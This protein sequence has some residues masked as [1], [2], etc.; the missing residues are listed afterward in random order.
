MSKKLF[1]PINF[2]ASALIVALA[3]S[4]CSDE[5]GDQSTNSETTSA[6]STSEGASTASGDGEWTFG[7]GTDPITDGA[8]SF[9]TAILSDGAFRVETK[10]GCLN[11]INTRYQFRFFDQ[12]GD[13]AEVRTVDN[14]YSKIVVRI[15]SKRSFDAAFKDFRFTN[16]I[17]LMGDNPDSFD[18]RMFPLN[19]A[20]FG[21]SVLFRFQLKTGDVTLNIDQNEPAIARALGECKDGI[22]EK[23]AAQENDVSTEESTE[24]TQASVND[25]E[26]SAA[27]EP[28]E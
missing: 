3:V 16:E 20:V 22:S 6:N 14:Q 26:Q 17:T 1:L 5:A 8:E 15:D 28:V 4:A 2:G 12:N 24:E 23:L 27:L 18:W 7:T 13:A 25:D 10:V 11:G 21:E 9:A 19:G